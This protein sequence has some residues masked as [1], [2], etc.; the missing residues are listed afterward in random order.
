MAD[1]VHANG[2]RSDPRTH[3][4]RHA[5]CHPDT[6]PLRRPRAVLH[7]PDPPRPQGP[8]LC[9]RHPP[10]PQT[11]EPVAERE[12]RSQGVRLWP[13]AVRQDRRAERDGDRLHD[14]IRRDAMVPRARD[15]AHIQAVHQGASPT[16]S[17]CHAF[18]ADRT[19]RCRPS[20]SGPSAASSRRCSRASRSSRDGTTTTS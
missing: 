10:R 20:T 13:R 9:G 19:R 3:G 8:A 11:I 6:R 12:L 17:A 18:R 1:G 16:S 7:L 15:H 4:D 14:R 2:T 5:P